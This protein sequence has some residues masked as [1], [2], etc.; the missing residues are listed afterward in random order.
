LIQGSKCTHLSRLYKPGSDTTCWKNQRGNT[1]EIS[2]MRTD[3]NP[4]KGMTPHLTQNL[5]A[6]GLWVFFLICCSTISF[7]PNVG[8]RLILEY[9]TKRNIQENTFKL[10]RIILLNVRSFKMLDFKKNALRKA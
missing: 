1:G 8:L 6:L 9:L 10:K 2:R 5:K 3:P 4:H 7:L